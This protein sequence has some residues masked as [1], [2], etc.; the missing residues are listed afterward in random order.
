MKKLLALV[1]ALCLTVSAVAA[2]AEE[3]IADYL[4]SHP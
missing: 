4:D 1:L 3:D 2:F